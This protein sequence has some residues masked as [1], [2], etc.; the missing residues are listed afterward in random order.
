MGSVARDLEKIM[1]PLAAILFIILLV[2]LILICLSSKAGEIKIR[3]KSKRL[4][5]VWSRVG[6]GGGLVLA[7]EEDRF[8]TLGFNPINI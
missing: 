2:I 8:C 4:A 1:I 7:A 6:S 3:I 5:A